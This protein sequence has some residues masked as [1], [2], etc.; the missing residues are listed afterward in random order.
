MIVICNSC[1]TKYSVDERKIPAA[2][3]KVRCHKCQNIILIKPPET[4]V[5]PPAAPSIPTPSKPVPST[6][7]PKPT[8]PEPVMPEPPSEPSVAKPIETPAP[9][10]VK[11]PEPEIQKPAFQPD[12]TEQRAITVPET[13]P[14]V[15]VPSEEGMSEEDKKWHQRA[16]RLAKALASDLVLYNQSKVEEGLRNGTLVRLLGAEIRRSWEY[17]CQQ[18]PKK[19]VDNTDY[20]KEQ[21]NK[22]VGKGKEIF[23]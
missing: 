4:S 7:P 8:M 10:T 1:Q 6:E 23:K 18:I 15:S 22:I 19:I 21:L 2:G 13:K 20:F 5:A 11:L 12:E 16:K 17:Y 9:P 14:S 3:V